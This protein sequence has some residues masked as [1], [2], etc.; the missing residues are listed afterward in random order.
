MSA[1]PGVIHP[2][3]LLLTTDW[4]V[5]RDPPASCTE[6]YWPDLLDLLGQ[7]A[8]H[9]RAGGADAVACAGDVFD[10]K[11]PSRT[12]HEVVI[13]LQRWIKE[14]P[15]PFYV[16]PGNH[17]MQHDRRDSLFATQPLGELLHSGARLLEG[18]EREEGFPIYGVPWQ[19][20]WSPARLD[21][22]LARYRYQ[23]LEA[24]TGAEHPLVITHA[25]I[26]PPDREPRYPGAE[27]T[28]AWW[29]AE[30]MGAGSVFYGHIHD[31]HGTYL[32]GDGDGTE[33]RFCNNGALSRGSLGG[34]NL[35]RQVG[36]TWWD[37]EAGAFDFIPLAARPGCEVL[38]PGL[39]AREEKETGQEMLGDFLAAVGEVQLPVLTAEGVVAEIKQRG[40]APEVAALA[41]EYLT[42]AAYAAGERR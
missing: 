14:L 3:R 27:V 15:C 40:V 7:V 32:V 34:D 29:W 30:A 20:R 4:H 8:G 12:P 25:P 13:A 28:P 5:R 42:A 31:F 10:H 22:V 16:T 17:D 35:D 26:Y 23:V 33:V 18:W 41:E 19:K 37:S 24:G 21:R 11:A 2:V 9:A 1:G 39:A 38:R 36:V 6:T